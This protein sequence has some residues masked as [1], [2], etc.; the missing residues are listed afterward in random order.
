MYHDVV[1]VDFEIIISHPMWV[2]DEK[3]KIFFVEVWLNP[4]RA[5]IILVI[6]ADT[7]IIIWEWNEAKIDK[8]IIFCVDNSIIKGFH[9]IPSDTPGNHWWAGKH[10]SL[11][12]IARH[13]NIDL[14]F[15]FIII[16]LLIIAIK[17]RIEPKAWIKK[18]FIILSEVD[19]FL[20]LIINGINV[21]IFN[22]NLIHI[23]NHEFDDNIIMILIIFIDRDIII[24]GLIIKKI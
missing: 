9:E 11:I 12:I 3:A 13:T 6:I 1:F 24:V 15:S 17:N 21:N 2:I 20:L 4:P 14:I 7:I 8:G 16:F 23:I 22:S 19:V 10:P 5:P 18:Y